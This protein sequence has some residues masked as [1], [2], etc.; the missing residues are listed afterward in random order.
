M[1]SE[2]PRR[3]P[4]VLPFVRHSDD[5]VIVGMAPSRIAPGFPSFRRRHLVA[6]EPLGDVILIELKASDHSREGLPHYHRLFVARSFGAQ[7][8]II[9]IGFA[10]SIS[11]RL[12]KGVAEI[13]G[14][15]WGIAG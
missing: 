13:H 1:K 7:C 5:V 6:L 12:S 2:V 3:I 8:R 11:V 10:L 15:A 4:G 14:F 9:F